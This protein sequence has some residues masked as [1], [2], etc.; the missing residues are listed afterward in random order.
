MPEKLATPPDMDDGMPYIDDLW[1]PQAQYPLSR[2]Q[3]WGWLMN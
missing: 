1:Q 3:A 2:A